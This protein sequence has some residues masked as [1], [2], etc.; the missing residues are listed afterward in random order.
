MFCTYVTSIDDVRFQ[1]FAASLRE[2]IT[3]LLR[4]IFAYL[5]EYSYSNSDDRRA[6]EEL[7]ILP[8]IIKDYTEKR[9]RKEEKNVRTRSNY[10]TACVRCVGTSTCNASSYSR[11]KIP[12]SVLSLRRLAINYEKI[13]RVHR[14]SVI[15]PT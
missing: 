1:L 14:A 2:I 7:F 13:I 11:K 12:Y 10:L 3:K 5:R 4:R 9:T 15:L 6:A 8:I